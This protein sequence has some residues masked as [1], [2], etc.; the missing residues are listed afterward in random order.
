MSRLTLGKDCHQYLIEEKLKANVRKLNI[1]YWFMYVCAQSLSRV[2]LFATPW[3]VACQAPLSREFF[4]ARIL[5]W[6]VISFSR[7]A[8]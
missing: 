2:P 3:T 5:E 4:Q 8:S 7:G 6:A 1:T